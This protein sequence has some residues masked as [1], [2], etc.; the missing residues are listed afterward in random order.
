[1]AC[2]LD[3]PYDCVTASELSRNIGLCLVHITYPKKV[4]SRVWSEK[5]TLSLYSNMKYETI[6]QRMAQIFCSTRRLVESF[7]LDV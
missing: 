3:S 5:I 7:L 1:M 4:Q 6:G 2:I